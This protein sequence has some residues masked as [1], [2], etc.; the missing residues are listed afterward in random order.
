MERIAGPS[1]AVIG[2]ELGSTHARRPASEGAPSMTF[3][4][5]LSV[6]ILATSTL[7]AGSAFSHDATVHAPADTT[8]SGKTDTLSNADKNFLRTAA[9]GGL[10]EVTL[11]KLAVKKATRE[12]VR[13]FGQR[14]VDDHSKVND[15]L[16]ALAT[17]KGFTPPTDLDEEHQKMLF[18]MSKMSGAEFDAHYVK[19]MIEDHDA[20]VA[21]FKTKSTNADDAEV[22]AFAKTTLPTL[23]AHQKAIKAI[24]AKMKSEKTP[25]KKGK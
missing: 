2:G 13:K 18:H 23:K 20:D 14:M 4:H 19:M 6:G 1:L 3:K 17:R 24:D 5:R 8:E 11:G 21:E 16:K 25:P 10:S 7:M 15:Q 12:D 9:I 22:R